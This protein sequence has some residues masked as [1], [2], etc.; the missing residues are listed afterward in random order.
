MTEL[1]FHKMHG[2]GND[3]M[4]FDA[5]NQSV[6][7]SEQQIR[8]WADRRFGVGFDQLLLVE[9]PT[10]LGV[11]FRYRIFNADGSEVAQCGNGARCFARFVRETGLSDKSVLVVE[12]ASGIIHLYHEAE[13][14]RVNMA[15]PRFAPEAL[16]MT[17]TQAPTYLLTVADDVIAFGAVSMGNPHAVIQVENIDT[18][19]VAAVGAALQARTDI[20]PQ[21]V[22]VGF[23]QVLGRDHVR[24][25]VYERGAGETMAC[26][27]GASAAMAVLRAADLVD[28][29]VR[30]S[31]LG[32]DLIIRWSGV[33]DEPLWMTGP[34]VT[35]FQGRIP[36]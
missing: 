28:E 2:L 33:L 7:L 11:D 35:V 13:G 15:A 30:V 34:A 18:A 25:R 8:A 3:F 20:F 32:G 29:S 5:I 21:S 22:N 9:S 12:T 26:G 16:P 17:L 14:V 23:V 36:V 1:V 10:Q 24:L 27:T 6:Q 4:V 31:L 19:P